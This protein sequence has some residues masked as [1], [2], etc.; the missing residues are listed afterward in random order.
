MVTENKKRILDFGN[1]EIFDNRQI[2]IKINVRIYP[3]D[4]VQSAAYILMDRAFALID[5]KMNSVTNSSL[6]SS[7]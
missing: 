3:L 5:G 4:V 1:M 7:T 6:R 2:T